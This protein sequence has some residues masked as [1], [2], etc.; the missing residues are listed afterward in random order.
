[1]ETL[2]LT[3][4]SDDRPG[5]V[6]TLSASLAARG[7]TWQR[8]QLSQLAGKFAGIVEVVVPADGV[9]GLVA[10]LDGL[11]AEGITVSTTRTSASSEAPTHHLTLDLVGADRPGIVAEVSALLS[12]R[13][14][15]IVELE[16]FVSEAPMAG[17][18]LFEAH[19]VLAAPAG[20]DEGELRAAMESLADE[21]MVDVALAEDA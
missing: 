4:I 21:L 9:D 13:G 2:V 7:A 15:G 12:A 14:I 11:S 16:T 6:A 17:G 1:M 8:S 3:V 20:A 10:D 18:M 5:L 19:A